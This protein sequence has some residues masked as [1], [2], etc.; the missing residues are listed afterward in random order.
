MKFIDNEELPEDVLG[1]I[2]AN[3]EQTVTVYLNFSDKDKIFNNNLEGYNKV[4]FHKRGNL[5][6]AE[7]ELNSFGA[8]IVTD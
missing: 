1:Y 6:E 3:S 4:L 7:I 2:R 5:N 8:L